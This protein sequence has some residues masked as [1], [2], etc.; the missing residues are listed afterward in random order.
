MP[1]LFIAIDLGQ[2]IQGAVAKAIERARPLAPKA[3]WVHPEASHVTLAFLGSRPEPEI[4]AI[5]KRLEA[6][7]SPHRPLSLQL[8]AAGTFGASRHPRVLWLGLAG[9]LEALGRLRASIEAGA[10]PFGYAAE[11]R[12]F[13]PHLTLA[14]SRDPKGELGLAACAT[15]LG[16]SI[17]GETRVDTVVLFRS[18]LSPKG[19]R[20]T[21]LF[22]VE[23]KPPAPP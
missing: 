17:Q 23:L 18:D 14:R 8:A 16:G 4:E 20:Y 3:K 7:A 2:T 11:Q 13:A 19:A 9:D 12:P 15:L 6:A 1:R 21:P 10:A 22:E 5:G